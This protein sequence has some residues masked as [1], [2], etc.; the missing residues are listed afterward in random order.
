VI[1]EEYVSGRELTVEGYVHGDD[2]V[3]LNFS[4]KLTETNFIVVGHYLP[5]LVS[6]KEAEILRTVATNCVRAVGMRN[7]VFHIEM[8]LSGDDPYVIECAA[9]PPGL[10][11][12]EL[13][14][15]TYGFDLM[16]ISLSLAVGEPVTEAPRDPKKHFA[17]LSLYSRTAGILDHIEG[18]HELQHRG[19]VAHLHFDVKPGDRIQPLSGLHQREG[20]VIL[21]D[22]T[23][24]GVRDKARWAREHVRFALL[25]D[26]KID[27]PEANVKMEFAIKE[28]TGRRL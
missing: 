28:I 1:V 20:F 25:R 14:Y 3:C 12:V 4:E 8:H 5:A 6:P 23:A 11:M 27:L 13:M 9:R 2:I 17:M 7:S 24:E 15:R 26:P 19:G 21:E 22:A 10:H 18:V 16:E